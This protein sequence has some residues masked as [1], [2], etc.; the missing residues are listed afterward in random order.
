MV[1]LFRVP[2]GPGFPGYG[3]SQNKRNP[4]T[5]AFTPENSPNEHSTESRENV[6]IA[7]PDSSPP[8]REP[9][10]EVESLSEAEL[11]RQRRIERFHSEPAHVSTQSTD[12]NTAATS[13][14][15]SGVASRKDTSG[16]SQL[17]S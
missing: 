11:I 12:A 17:Q 13:V 4:Q 6:S 9:Q 2:A 10:R 1:I 16:S 3:S 8:L 5:A 14:G 15:E 7:Q